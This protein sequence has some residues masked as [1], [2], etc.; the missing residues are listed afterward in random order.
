M[1][2][3]GVTDEAR[4]VAAIPEVESNKPVVNKKSVGGALAPQAVANAQRP[5]AQA[6]REI[7]AAWGV[8]LRAHRQ[9]HVH[10]RMNGRVPS[11]RKVGHRVDAN[12]ASS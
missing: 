6:P 5:E 7:F 9:C 3:Q 11:T 4:V 2:G 10:L 8:C 12:I 1:W